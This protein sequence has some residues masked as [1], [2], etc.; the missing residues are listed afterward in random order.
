MEYIVENCSSPGA[1]FT[2]NTNH[3]LLSIFD[4]IQEKNCPILSFK[5]FRAKIETDK[6]IND[7]NAR[8]IYPLAKNCGMINY[9]KGV[10][11]DTSTFFTNT[12]LAYVK[13]LDTKRIINSSDY[14]EYQKKETSKKI[15]EITNVLVYSGLKKL[16]LISSNY[17]DAFKEFIRFLVHY[18]KINRY[19]FSYVLYLMQKGT[20]N[21]IEDI[22]SVITQYRNELITLNPKISVRNDITIRESTSQDRRVEGIG[23]LSSFNYFSGL[24][25]QAGLIYKD[26]DYFVYYHD[27]EELLKKLLED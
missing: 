12:G 2:N 11:L 1:S 16:L 26:D 25:Q 21:L 15:D 8:N 7:N 10:D 22:K 20:T 13:A 23:F 4:W 5:E 14:S 3:V 17:Q 27:K 19:E 24:L 6:Q 9:E 18:N